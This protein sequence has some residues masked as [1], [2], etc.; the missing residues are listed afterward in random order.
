MLWPAPTTR[1]YKDGTAQ[2]C[3]NVPVN[4]L[5]GRAVHLYPTPIASDWKNRGNRDYRKGQEFNYRQRLVGS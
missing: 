2:A 3:R 4:G 1:D 5:L